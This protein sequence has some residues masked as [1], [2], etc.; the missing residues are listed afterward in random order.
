MLRSTPQIISIA[1]KWHHS[2]PSSHYILCNGI[3]CNSYVTE[4]P[5]PPTIAKHR[6]SSLPNRYQAY[7]HDDDCLFMTGRPFH[8]ERLVIT[9]AP[10]SSRHVWRISSSRH[11]SE[12]DSS[13]HDVECFLVVL[14]STSDTNLKRA[15]GQLSGLYT[16]TPVRPN[17]KRRGQCVVGA[18]RS[19]S[20]NEM[21][22]H[23]TI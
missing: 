8:L 14:C 9:A 13:S 7:M 17:S 12:T 15:C 18:S 16:W 20:K 22:W 6:L 21:T 11:R 2:H 1:N 23:E 10:H 3:S 4:N 5:T 19:K